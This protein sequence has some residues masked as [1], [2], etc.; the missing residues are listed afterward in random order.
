M[1]R[2]VAHLWGRK[3]DNLEGQARLLLYDIHKGGEEEEAREAGA[4]DAVAFGRCLGDVPHG[5]EPISDVADDLRLIA[6]LDYAAGVVGDRAE[7]VHGKHVDL[8]ANHMVRQ[9]EWEREGWPGRGREG[10]GER[11]RE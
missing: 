9:G 10:Q 8:G 6:H 4:A 11:V 1:V 2:S 7:G 3:I 5:V